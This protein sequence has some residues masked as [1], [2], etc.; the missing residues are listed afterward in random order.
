MGIAG[1]GG[2]LAGAKAFT[3]QMK[4]MRIELACGE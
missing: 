3:F 4:R 2:A 1:V